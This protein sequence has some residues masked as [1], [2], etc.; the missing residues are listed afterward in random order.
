[1][2]PESDFELGQVVAGQVQGR[3]GPEDITLFES[4]R[5]ALEDTAGARLV[6]NRA[7]ERGRGCESSN[8]DE[9]HGSCFL[10]APSCSPP[11]P[12]GY[13]SLSGELFGKVPQGHENLC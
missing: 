8:S 12:S 9:H 11:G 13:A 2:L 1:M 4:H 6:F 7:Q 5:L 3:Q 10:A